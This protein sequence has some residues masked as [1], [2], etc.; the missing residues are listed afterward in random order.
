MDTISKRFIVLAAF[1]VWL[2]PTVSFAAEISF[3]SPKSVF[4]PN[5]EFLVNVYL[6]GQNV[7]VNALEGT[8]HFPSEL[9]E[10]KEVRD[11]NSA[12]NFW[13]E[14]PQSTTSD[15]VA[16]SGITPSGFSGS[17]NFIFGMVFRAKKVGDGRLA[18]ENIQVLQND[19]LGTAAAV[20]SK[21]FVFSVSSD[22][23]ATSSEDLT[24][25]DNEPPETFVPFVGND[26]TVFAGKYFLVFS[27]QDKGSG[28]DHYEVREGY[29]GRYNVVESPYLLTDQS[30]DKDIYVKAVDKSGNEIV[31]ILNAEKPSWRYQYYL[32]IVILI[33]ICVLIYKKRW[34]NFTKN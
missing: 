11:G 5:E 21:E 2:V 3:G 24:V 32:V 25:K 14:K 10:L 22:K 31:V 12:V 27:T 33:S 19:G 26:P 34:L 18:F 16:F 9:L 23:P 28:I 13:I 1:L 4:A 15:S 7:L 29:W 8:V 6:D 30:L 17:R 20:N